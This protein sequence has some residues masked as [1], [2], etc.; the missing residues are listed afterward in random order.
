[1]PLDILF[2]EI[3]ATGDGY[4]P[5]KG[6]DLTWEELDENLK[7]LADAI[8]QAVNGG[9]NVQPYDNGDTYTNTLPDYVTYGGNLWKCLAATVTG[10][11][12]GTDPTKWELSSAGSLTH[13][14]NTDTSLAA[15]TA[16]AVTAAEIREF[17][18]NQLI[19]TTEGTFTLTANLGLLKINR[20]YKLTDSTPVLFIRTL[21][22]AVW[23]KNAVALMRTPLVLNLWKSNSAGGSYAINQRANFDGYVFRNKTGTNTDTPPTTDGT[24]WEILATTTTAYTDS[25]F[26]VELMYQVGAILPILYRD[27]LNG[28]SFPYITGFTQSFPQINESNTLNELDKSSGLDVANAACVIGSNVLSHTSFI[29]LPTGSEGDAGGLGVSSN[30]LQN[31]TIDCG[32]A[33]LGHISGNTLENVELAIDNGIEDGGFIE[34]CGIS[35]SKKTTLEIRTKPEFLGVTISENGSTAED[36]ITAPTGTIDLEQNGINDAYGVYWFTGGSGSVDTVT[37]FKNLFPVKIECRDPGERL[38]VEIVSAGSATNGSLVC[39]DPSFTPGTY[40]LDADK[41][42]YLKILEEITVGG[43]TALLVELVKLS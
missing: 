30:N 16:N 39:A 12:P 31:A 36:E 29:I 1:M 34:N 15:G 20:V 25:Y 5:P 14:Q 11:I 32:A 17:L 21:S 28:N 19:L 24:N 27:Q 26:E 2:R 42:E 43:S 4:N 41:G 3:D 7:T 10:V 35:F 40:D 8:N 23:S 9:G 6:S 13:Q 38:A 37:G 22:T 18:S 33:M